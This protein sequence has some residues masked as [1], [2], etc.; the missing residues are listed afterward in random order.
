M[1]DDKRNP[2]IRG[3]EGLHLMHLVQITCTKVFA[4]IMRIG[5]NKSPGPDGIQAAINKLVIHLLV[6]QLQELFIQS[7]NKGE[8]LQD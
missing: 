2:D 7:F 1:D 3:W 5:K 6:P 4:M 8:C